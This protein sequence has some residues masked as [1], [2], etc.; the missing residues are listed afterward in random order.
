MQYIVICYI[1]FFG[2]KLL[3][4]KTKINKTI[5]L[6]AVFAAWFIIDSLFFAIPDM[7]FLRARQMFSFPLGMVIAKN[8]RPLYPE[9]EQLLW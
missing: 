2:M 7:P 1:L 3:I 4:E 9:K 6:I 5:T 8:K